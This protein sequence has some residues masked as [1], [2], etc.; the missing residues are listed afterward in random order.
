MAALELW[1]QLQLDEVNSSRGVYSS[2][3]GT[4]HLEKW[5]SLVFGVQKRKYSLL[6]I[7]YQLTSTYSTNDHKWHKYGIADVDR[8]ESDDVTRTSIYI[9]Y[10]HGHFEVVRSI[11]P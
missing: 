6:P 9:H 10:P 3:Y 7:C 4:L 11:R 8:N 5:I 1:P 2:K